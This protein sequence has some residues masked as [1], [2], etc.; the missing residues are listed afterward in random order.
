MPR[1]PEG[2]TPNLP[3]PRALKTLIGAESLR[4]LYARLHP[5][6]AHLQPQH[7]GQRT[8]I[9]VLAPRQLAGV[10]RKQLALEG[11]ELADVHEEFRHESAQAHRVHP[12][13]SW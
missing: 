9:G 6:R 10:A 13:Q 12:P 5:A 11:N 7:L 2:G 3:G 1:P 4:S 8:E